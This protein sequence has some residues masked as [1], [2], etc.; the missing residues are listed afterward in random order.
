MK[1]IGAGPL[2][3]ADIDRLEQRIYPH[4]RAYYAAEF[5]ALRAGG[6][7]LD[8]VKQHGT[9]WGFQQGCRCHPCRGAYRDHYTARKK[10][11]A[12]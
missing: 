8:S 5:A 7:K 3:P 2:S 6:V 4:R 9:L 12:S 11:K 10:R 1:S